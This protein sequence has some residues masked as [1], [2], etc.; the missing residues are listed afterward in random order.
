MINWTVEDSLSGKNGELSWEVPC[1]TWCP[2]TG[3]L[4][5]VENVPVRLDVGVLI[6]QQFF[7]IPWHGYVNTLIGTIPI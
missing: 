1:W 7:N 6:I 3:W 2:D 5:D 4:H